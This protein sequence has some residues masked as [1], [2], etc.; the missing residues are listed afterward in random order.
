MIKINVQ[1]E[2][3][4]KLN[5]A[6][7]DAVNKIRSRSYTARH[8]ELGRMVNCPVCQTRHYS[9]KVC[10]QR[11]S[12]ELPKGLG[13]SFRK[14][15]IK[16]HHNKYDL[17]L[18]EK[19]REL[20]KFHEPYFSDPVDTMKEARKEARRELIRKRKKLTRFKR[21]QQQVAR[22]INFGLLP[23]GTRVTNA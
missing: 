21:Q 8:P 2:E 14:K 6:V 4:L 11:Y 17:Q 3:I 1:S 19:T 10:E 5:Q 7:V 9:S 18:I 15:R 22:K 16:P 13:S 20:F 12:V 23:A